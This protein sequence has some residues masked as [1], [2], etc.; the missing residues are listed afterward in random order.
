M[1]DCKLLAVKGL[2]ISLSGSDTNQIVIGSVM[3]P[4]KTG[5]V[6]PEPAYWVIALIAMILLI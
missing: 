1:S 2:T 3:A 4:L 5:E 6:I